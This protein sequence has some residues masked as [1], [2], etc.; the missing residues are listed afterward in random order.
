MNRFLLACVFV[1]VSLA[2]AP[3]ANAQGLTTLYSTIGGENDVQGINSVPVGPS[4]LGTFRIATA[5]TPTA[6]GDA[7]LVSMRGQC[8]IPYPTGTT[9]LGIGQISIQADDGGKPSGTTLGTM[10]FYLT[11]TLNGQPVREQCGTLSPRVHL[12]AGTK[13]WAVMTAP[14]QIAWLDWREAAGPQVLQSINDGEWTS[15]PNQKTLAL[16]IDAGRD[17]CVPHAETIPTPG[18]ELGDMYVRTGQTAFNTI[19]VQNTGVAPLTW[20]SASFS[21]GDAGVFTLIDQVFG[22]APKLPMQ[23][24]TGALKILEVRCT[25]GATERWYRAT[26]TLHTNDPDTPDLQ[27]PVACMVDNTPPVWSKFGPGPDGKEGWYVHP[28][29]VTVN[30]IDP[31]PGSGTKQSFCQRGGQQWFDYGGV[32]S[33]SMTAE[34]VHSLACDA[35]DVAGNY[36]YADFGSYKL[37]TR[38]PVVDPVFDPEPTSD[39]WN[40]T[41]ASVR[42]ECDDPTPGSGVDEPADGGGR[43]DHE[44]TGV[45][46]T[47]SGCTDI[48]GNVSTPVTST[49]RIDMTKPVVT[50]AD[51]S[52]APNAQG[53]NRNDVTI[54]FDCQDTGGVQSGIRTDTVDDITVTQ[55]T[56]GTTFSSGG[57]CDDKAAN[58]AARIT[59]HIKL[60]KTAPTTRITAGA[61]ATTTNVND[62]EIAIAGSDDRSGVAGLECRADGGDWAA[63]TSPARFSDLPDGPHSLSVRAVDVAGNVDAS[64]EMLAWTVDT[65]A[66]QTTIDGG[67]DGPTASAGASF[68]Y[69]G[70]TLGGTAIASY[71][72][73]VDDGAWGAC[74]ALAGLAQGEHRF[75]VR[76]T[77]AAGNVDDTPATRTW[78][79]DTIVPE[80]T[81]KTGPQ[82]AVN[83]KTA[84][85]TYE[86]DA[87]G[88]T[89][90]TGYECRLDGGAWAACA[91]GYG[92]LAEGDHT[93]AARAV[94]AAGNRDDTPAE[95]QWLVD[96]IA[97]D[98]SITGGPDALTGARTATFVFA[99]DTLGGSPVGGYECRLD[100]GDWAACETLYADIPGGEHTLRARAVDAAGNRDGSPAAYTWTVDATPPETAID[101]GPDDVTGSRTATFAYSA[102]ALGGL[103][104]TQFECRLDD[105]AWGTCPASYTDLEGGEHTFRVRATDAGGN[106]DGSPAARTWTVDLVA[107]ATHI[108]GEPDARTAATDATFAFTAD[109]AGGSTVAGFECQLDGAGYAPCASGIAYAGLADGRHTFNVRAADAVG[110]VESPGASYEWSISDFFAADD[111][112]TT[113]E[114]APVTI[115][116]GANDVLSGGV[117]I[118]A[119]AHS[120]AGGTVTAAGAGRLRYAPPADWS[121]TDRF[122]YSAARGADRTTATVIVHVLDVNDPPAF[123]AGSTIVVDEDSGPYRGRWA[124]AISAGESGQHVRFAVT[125]SNTALFSAQ[126]AVAP[127]G[128]LTFT[129]APDASGSATVTIRALDDGG[130]ERTARLTITVNPVDDPPTVSVARDVRCGR[131]Q[132]GTFKLIAHD[133]DSDGSTLRISG[134]A[135]TSRVGLVFGGSGNERTVSISRR[136]GLRRATVTVRLTDGAHVFRI[137]VRLS[138][139]TRG[140]DRIRGTSGPDLLFGL[141]GDDTILGRGGNDLICGGN[142]ADRLDGG[143]GDDVVIGGRGNDVVIGGR[144]DDVVRG[145]TGADELI[146]GDGDDIL[147]GGPRGDLFAP[148]PGADTLVDFNEEQGDRR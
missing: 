129:P 26:L 24:G 75:Q 125:N 120:E 142:G 73:R 42:F 39:G 108:T 64:P 112:A 78:T 33:L 11:D 118:T 113:R 139:G 16:R 4:P 90:V 99:S 65:V 31:E 8:V 9:C 111:E 136:P 66:P 46:F 36:A 106:V 116:V 52:P 50:V 98:T 123:R 85:F 41:A 69:S 56:S 135:T 45:D 51:V 3:A 109:D 100:D 107:P 13:Y 138:V 55:E 83:A 145:D 27:F 74:A 126:P 94:D 18:T 68:A 114:D 53:W 22:Q 115:D 89:A 23:I 148:A 7:S 71:E 92:D 144:G 19:S 59:Q 70:D 37:D 79:V 62:A 20:S 63:C 143:A 86:S 127:S 21:G 147:R 25:G 47:S 95:W 12:N 67:P 82:S 29:A 77:D 133:I 141:A 119:D 1:F 32:K 130:A 43:V 97:P 57:T 101:S 121:G 84:A 40:N 117:A 30:A 91:D 2:L 38:A 103:A 5:F 6:T 81:I 131:S 105:A 76:A 44:T 14:D 35:Y 110:N 48:A 146:G 54:A 102:D 17:E 28:I 128:E 60:D 34:G 124:S 10:G 49:I 122:T 87:L 15:A 104:V 58:A 137:P 140:A 72:C 96:T 61:P 132:N 134:S 88:G 93:L 80:T